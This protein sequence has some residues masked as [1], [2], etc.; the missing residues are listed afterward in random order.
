YRWIS[1]NGVPRYDAEKNFSGYIGS[2]VDITELVKKEEVLHEFEERVT[3]AAKAAHLGVWELDIA[4]NEVWMS[5][6]ARA[7]FGFDSR[8][9][10]NRTA[11]QE[12]VHPEDRARRDGAVTA[13]IETLGEYKI[14]YRILLP[15]RTLRWISGRGRCVSR[16]NKGIRLI[17]VSIDITPQKQTQELFR[18]ATEAS[19]SGII[20]VD[21]HGRIVLVNSHAEELFGYGRDELVGKPVE[22]LVPERFAS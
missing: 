14:E 9:P 15:D 3:L 11:I 20:L 22:V 21:D 6:S 13:A 17:G 5:D 10:V 16:Q 19:P 2:C 12:R 18:L 1:D 7:L 8:A 4:T